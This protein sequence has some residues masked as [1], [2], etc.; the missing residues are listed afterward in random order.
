[1][2]EFF[3]NYIVFSRVDQESGVDDFGMTQVESFV[4]NLTLSDLPSARTA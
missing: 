2:I 1:M 3:K 4:G